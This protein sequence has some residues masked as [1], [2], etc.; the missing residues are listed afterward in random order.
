MTKLFA[1][2]SVAITLSPTVTRPIDRPAEKNSSR[3]DCRRIA[4]P[5]PSDTAR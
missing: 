2:N 4:N 1:E 3:F 5:S